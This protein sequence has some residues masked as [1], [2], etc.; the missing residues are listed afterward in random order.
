MKTKDLRW[1]K[2]ATDSSINVKW[3]I[4][5]SQTGRFPAC[6]LKYKPIT[7]IV[8]KQSIISVYF[9]VYFHSPHLHNKIK[10]HA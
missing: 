8:Q 2:T 1:L 7:C 9:G 6:L 4:T 10:Y 5:V 3:K